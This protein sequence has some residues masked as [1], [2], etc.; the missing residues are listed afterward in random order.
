MKA[1]AVALIWAPAQARNLLDLL[2]GTKGEGAG[3]GMD[4]ILQHERNESELS[5]TSHFH[6]QGM[7]LFLHPLVYYLVEM[8]QVTQRKA[9]S[10]L[11]KSS[12]LRLKVSAAALA[13]GISQRSFPGEAKAERFSSISLPSGV[14]DWR[15]AHTH[16][17]Q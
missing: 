12:L 4:T 11:G 1:L 15:T 10:V 7:P 17:K 16:T 5:Y 9:N 8:S 3:Q 2:R 6:L 14:N 13:R